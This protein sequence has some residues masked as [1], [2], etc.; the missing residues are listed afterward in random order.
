MGR[1]YGVPANRVSGGERARAMGQE[2]TQSARPAGPATDSPTCLRQIS[3]PVLSIRRRSPRRR[4]AGTEGQL[5]SRRS[6]TIGLRSTMISP[7]AP[8]P[9]GSLRG[10]RSTLSCALSDRYMAVSSDVPPSNYRI[11]SR[12]S[13]YA[14]P[15]P[16][17]SQLTGQ[18]V[19]SVQGW[20]E[21]TVWPRPARSRGNLRWENG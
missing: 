4:S 9:R 19:S 13:V 16:R 2:G 8:R 11:L 1:A 3:V 7:S 18:I 21:A 12:A 17:I 20:D 6:A 5:S 10:S 14:S 15:A